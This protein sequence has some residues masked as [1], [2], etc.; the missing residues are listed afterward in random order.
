[1]VFIKYVVIK[2]AW[3]FIIKYSRKITN[4]IF[5]L[6]KEDKKIVIMKVKEIMKKI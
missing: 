5:I 3:I 4:K 1:M 6:L 2:I